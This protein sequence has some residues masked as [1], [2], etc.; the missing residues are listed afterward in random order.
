[1]RLGAYTPIEEERVIKSCPSSLRTLSIDRPFNITEIELQSEN[2]LT[3]SLFQLDNLRVL[4]LHCPSLQEFACE[5][6]PRIEKIE[7]NVPN[8]R[9]LDAEFYYGLPKEDIV[10]IT[11]LQNLE[12]LSLR[13]VLA[14]PPTSSEGTTDSLS[15][16]DQLA[17]GIQTLNLLMQ[18]IER[19]NCRALSFLTVLGIT[20]VAR[21]GDWMG[22][23]LQRCL[24]LTQWSL[25]IPSAEKTEI[26]QK[27]GELGLQI[28]V[29]GPGKDADLLALHRP[30]P[31]SGNWQAF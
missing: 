19:G 25:H 5:Y 21:N 17:A 8:L 2:L 26:L 18:V 10:F 9:K 29:I 28:E 7:L 27:L 6:L 20:S 3:L 30:S 15:E 13:G 11:E 31:T 14:F 4:K 24:N 16:E 1:M 22:R 23:V 12:S